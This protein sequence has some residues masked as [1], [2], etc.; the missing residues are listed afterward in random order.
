MSELKECSN[1]GTLTEL[2]VCPKCDIIL[3][4]KNKGKDRY[5]IRVKKKSKNK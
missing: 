1:C 3:V 5:E 4:G 2:D